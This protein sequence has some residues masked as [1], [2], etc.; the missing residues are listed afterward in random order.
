MPTRREIRLAVGRILKAMPDGERLFYEF[1]NSGTLTASLADAVNLKSAR[2]TST[3]FDDY[4]VRWSDAS[5]AAPDGDKVKA[6]TLVNST[7]VLSVSPDLS[8]AAAN[9]DTG[10]LWQSDPD[11]VDQT[12]DRALTQVTTRWRPVPLGFLQDPDFLVD[13]LADATPTNWTGSSATA[14]V[15][16]RSGVERFSERVLRV[17]NSGADG[18]AGQTVNTNL[19]AN[20]GGEARDWAFAALVQADVGTA[21]PIIY[22]L[23]NSAAL[24]LNGQRTSWAGEGFQLIR[25]SVTVPATCEQ[26]S[27][28]LHGAEVNADCYW[29]PVSFY[30]KDATEF[31]LPARFISTSQV[32]PALWEYVGDDFPEQSLQE[33]AVRPT[34]YD[35][36]GGYIR[37]QLNDGPIG[38]RLLYVREFAF[39][40]AFATVYNTAAARRTADALNTLC[41]VDYAA[42][43]TL[44]LMFPGRFDRELSAVQRRRGARPVYRLVHPQGEVV[45]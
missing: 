30:P 9:L 21:S 17:A 42:W 38:E 43:A 36:G 29:G 3:T 23:S 34:I 25:V 45:A 37:L 7:G 20:T 2:F 10:E 5:G 33:T 27:V 13:E 6:T 8:A 39:Y 11:V 19:G 28:R 16:N 14:T 15:T 40:N 44:S 41:P 35:A 24:T 4:W 12:I 22:D 32:A 31:V 18:Y 26:V 1:V